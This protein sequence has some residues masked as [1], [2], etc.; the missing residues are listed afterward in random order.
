MDEINVQRMIEEIQAEISEKHWEQEPILF[1]EVPVMDCDA[2]HAGGA[3]DREFLRAATNEMNQ[4]W[5]IRAYRPLLGERIKVFIKRVFRKL[6]KF[7]IE[8]VTEDISE[9]N[10]YTV[11]SVNSICAYID[12]QQKQNEKLSEKIDRLEQEVILLKSKMK[13]LE[14]T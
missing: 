5:E 4:R 3:F 1:D 7:Y 9:Y 6:M 10:A 13:K 2:L 8:P 12:E 11:R 14:N